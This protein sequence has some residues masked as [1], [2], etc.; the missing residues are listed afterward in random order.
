MKR[1]GRL[2][3]TSK[4][5]LVELRGRPAVRAA[6]LERDGGCLLHLG[7]E[8]NDGS[9]GPC[10]GGLTYHHLKKASQGG[11]YTIENG[12]TLCAHHNDLV[13]DHPTRAASIGL[14]RRTLDTGKEPC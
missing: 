6:V 10:F 2:S 13:E 12:A 8:L 5:R 9:W 11:E 14:V 3:P 7:R 1:G 4:K